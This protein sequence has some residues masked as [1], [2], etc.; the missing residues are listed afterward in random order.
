VLEHRLHAP[1]DY[2]TAAADLAEGLDLLRADP[3]VD[4]DRIA[5]WVFSGGGLLLTDH[6]AAPAP[7]LRCVAA[8]YPVLA[9]PSSWPGVDPHFRPAEALAKAGGLPVVLTRAGLESPEFAAAV[10]EFVAEAEACGAALELVDVPQGRHGFDCDEPTEEA[11]GA[12]RQA[13]AAV[14]A[15]LTA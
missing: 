3:R 7:W 10:A 11:R 13:L 9:A 8:T 12:V 4:P 14:R 5:V 15:N 2:R 6:L 1:S